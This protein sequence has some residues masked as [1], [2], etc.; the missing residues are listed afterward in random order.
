MHKSRL[1]ALIVD[2]QTE[3]LWKDAQF[4]SGALGAR[5][6]DPANQV[7][8]KYIRL[9][10][11]PNELRVLLQN[12]DH[13]SRVHIDIET[14]DIEAEVNRLVQ[15]GATIVDRLERWVVMQAPSGHRFC[16]IGTISDGFEEH[17]NVWT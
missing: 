13:S 8:Q 3:D 7:N 15:L 10:S 5:C 12:V 9:E 16:V 14:D 2:C 1:G 11:G 4:W 6:E 17:A